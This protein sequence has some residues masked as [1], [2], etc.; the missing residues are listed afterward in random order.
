MPVATRKP[1]GA[2]PPTPLEEYVDTPRLLARH[3]PISRSTLDRMI[4]GGR[5]PQPTMRLGRRKFWSVRVVE[6]WLAEQAAKGQ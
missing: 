3:L 4:A 2:S 6:A 1:T 5:F